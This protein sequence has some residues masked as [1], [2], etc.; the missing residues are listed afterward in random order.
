MIKWRLYIDGASKNNPGPS[1]A[2]IV[3]IKDDKI[4]FQDGFFLGSKTNNQ[5]EYLALLV[6]LFELGKKRKDGDD[7]TI[8]SDSQL[9]VRQILGQYKVKKSH[10]QPLHRFAKHIINAWGALVMHVMRSDNEQAD[11]MANVGVESKKG[12]PSD[13]VALLNEHEIQI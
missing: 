1:G 4:I 10:L 6:G 5:A 9:L 2:G 11:R 7:V 13:F 8:I 3:I 12:L